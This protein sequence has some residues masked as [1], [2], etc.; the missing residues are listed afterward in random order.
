MT[1]KFHGDVTIYGNVETYSNGSMKI[2]QVSPMTIPLTELE[3][4]IERS[5]KDSPNKEDYLKATDVLKNSKDIKAIQKSALKLRG[6]VK[7]IG[8][9]SN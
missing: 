5:L 7:E 4:F 8:R 3:Q 1:I 2:I 9:T 6:V